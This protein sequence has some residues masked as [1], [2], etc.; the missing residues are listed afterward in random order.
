MKQN[1]LT[2]S[3]ESQK[4]YNILF[5]EMDEMYNYFYTNPPQDVPI[6][7]K[8]ELF[9]LGEL[10]SMLYYNPIIT[11]LN[12]NE[13]KLLN[14]AEYSTYPI[15]TTIQYVSDALS[16]PLRSFNIINRRDNVKFIRVIIPNKKPKNEKEEHDKDKLDKAMHLCG[17]YV[18]KCKYYKGDERFLDIT[19]EPKYIDEANNIVRSNKV[20]YHLSPLP[21]KG[22]ILKKGFI[23]SSKNTQF[24]YPDRSYFFLGNVRKDEIKTW[25]PVF[26]KYVEKYNNAPFC[27]YTIDVNKIPEDVTFYLDPNLKGGC[28]TAD[29]ISPYT[30]VSVE[31]IEE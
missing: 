26:R 14:E 4:M 3:E 16:I 25:I 13:S 24:T 27:L 22:K 20:L 17:Y 8:R 19:Y 15:E 28:Y 18:A 5:K 6:L 30:I 23:P 10:S 1:S 12:I 21:Y 9:E 29:N 2:I 11:A 7:E 31:E